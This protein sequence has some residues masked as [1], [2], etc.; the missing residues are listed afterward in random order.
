MTDDGVRI[1]RPLLRETFGEGAQRTSVNVDLVIRD[2]GD[3][4]VEGHDIGAAPQEIFGDSDYE[5]WLTVRSE[6]KGRVLEALL[7]ESAERGAA[8]DEDALLIDLLL[9]RFGKSPMPH[10]DLQNWLGARAIPY[11]FDSYA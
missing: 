7:A 8:T 10:G 2:N 6:E 11:S 9:A 1:R 3:M 4:I 5:Y